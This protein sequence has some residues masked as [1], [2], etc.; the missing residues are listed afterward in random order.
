MKI[1]G[2]KS[3]VL[4]LAT[5]SLAA[6]GAAQVT[7]QG[8]GYDIKVKYNPGQTYTF[9]L[10]TAVKMS[11]GPQGMPGG[12]TMAMTMRQQVL[13]VKNGIATLKVSMVGG[14]GGNQPP[15][16]VQVNNRGKIVGGAGANSG[17]NFLNGFPA[18]PIKVG[19]RWSTQTALPMGQMG[20]GKANV[21]YVFRGMRNVGGKQAAQIDF[22]IAMGG[23]AALKGSGSAFLSAADG[24]LLNSNMKGN[25]SISQAGMGN[26]PGAKPMNIG[27]NVNMKRV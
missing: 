27:L 19:E 20:Q 22:T 2:T 8:A 26:R 5:L 7:K 23:P 15:S 3:G 1:Q 13:S 9:A 6:L 14:P 10:N 11:G 21:S 24:Q 25:V 12:Q 16:T 18:R 17:Y 4:A